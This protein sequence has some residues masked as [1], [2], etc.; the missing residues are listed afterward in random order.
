[1]NCH[2]TA[3]PNEPMKWE[4]APEYSETRNGIIFRAP[5]VLYLNR[6]D[7]VV[8]ACHRHSTGM[9]AVASLLPAPATSCSNCGRNTNRTCAACGRPVCQFHSRIL[10][11]FRFCGV[12]LH[13]ADC[14]SA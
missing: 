6:R 11:E 7:E 1:M 2:K 10:G 14:E 12:R 3:C 8:T 4:V 13:T 9:Q 5:Y